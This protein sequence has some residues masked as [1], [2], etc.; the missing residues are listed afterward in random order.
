MDITAHAALA[1]A[2]LAGLLGG[3]HCFAM[4]GAY[5]TALAQPTAAPVRLHP[6]SELVA[7]NL[8][9]HAGRV[10]TYV[11]LGALA[12][13]AGGIALAAQWQAWQRML[14]VVANVLL[15]ALAFAVARGASLL[16]PLE[17]AGLR[18][19]AWALP[20]AKPILA[21]SD[22]P[23]RFAFGLVWGLTPCALVYGVLPIA[24][25]AGS[26]AEGA[27]VMLAFG[28]GTL[29]NLAAAGWLLNRGRR[30]L[31]ARA[32]RLAGAALI[33]AFALMGIWR[34][35]FVPE[36]LGQGPFCLFG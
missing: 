16:V 5:L 30:Y 29:P 13:A 9:A 32:A 19:Y 10:T 26:G 3:V 18:V 35:L 27:L 25:L 8:A 2:L 6:R 34:A 4:C 24:L 15:L 36:A 17:R 28:L 11:T 22:L 21:R 12:G 31:G 23:A 14:Y 7:A 33:G 20:A 1:G